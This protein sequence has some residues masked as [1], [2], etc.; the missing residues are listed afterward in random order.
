MLA[1]TLYRVI[2]QEA[3]LDQYL[4]KLFTQQLIRLL[5]R[6]AHEKLEVLSLLVLLVQKQKYCC[7]WRCVCDRLSLSGG[8]LAH[9]QLLLYQALSYWCMRP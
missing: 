1:T 6:K 7:T 9:H 5:K 2:T 4:Q 8:P 3:S